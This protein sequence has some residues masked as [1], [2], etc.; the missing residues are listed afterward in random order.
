MNFNSIANGLIASH[1]QA[2]GRRE[3]QKAE[4]WCGDKEEG[5]ILIT[6]SPPSRRL[7]ERRHVVVSTPSSSSSVQWFGHWQVATPLHLIRTLCGNFLYT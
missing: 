6:P 3:M 5:V 2:R 7:V 4:R 1:T